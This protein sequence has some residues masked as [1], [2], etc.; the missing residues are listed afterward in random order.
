MER[1]WITEDNVVFR[2]DTLDGLRDA[3]TMAEHVE[4]DILFTH[5]EFGHN[6]N[7]IKHAFGEI[8]TQ[9]DAPLALARLDDSAFFGTSSYLVNRAWIAKVLAAVSRQQRINLAWDMFMK[10]CSATSH[11]NVFACAPDLTGVGIEP[12]QIQG[13]A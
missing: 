4:W 13:K 8:A 6:R 10:W 11:L 5:I 3:L 7:G 9:A 12:S 2:P 1:L